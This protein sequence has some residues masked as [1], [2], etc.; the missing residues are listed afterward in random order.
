[1]FHNEVI[2]YIVVAWHEF[3]HKVAAAPA[4]GAGGNVIEGVLHRE[5]ADYTQN[6]T[7]GDSPYWP[8]Y[9]GAPFPMALGLP[10]RQILALIEDPIKVPEREGFGP[11]AP[12][13]TPNFE[14]RRGARQIRSFSSRITD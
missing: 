11:S 6:G 2:G 9:F 5:S 3:D 4:A 12:C 7:R 8:A 14:P 1:V 10:I 13:G